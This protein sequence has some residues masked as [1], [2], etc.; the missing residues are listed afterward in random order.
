MSSNLFSP[1]RNVSSTNHVTKYSE[2]LTRESWLEG[3]FTW[4]LPVRNVFFRSSLSLGWNNCFQSHYVSFITD[5]WLAAVSCQLLSGNW[6]VAW[7]GSPAHLAAGGSILE[8]VTAP[9]IAPDEHVGPL[10]PLPSV[11]E[12]VIVTSAELSERSV[13]WKS[14]IEMHLVHL[15]NS[16]HIIYVH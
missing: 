13:D 14:V 4:V 15:C 9:Q 6:K 11:C 7:F 12:Q 2:L 3:T 1:S 5:M 16:H 10:Q 8:Q